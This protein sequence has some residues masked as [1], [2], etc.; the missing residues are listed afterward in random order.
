MEKW[1]DKGV[2][3]GGSDYF[4]PILPNLK[5]LTLDAALFC[6]MSLVMLASRNAFVYEGG[7]SWIS[8][9]S[10]AVTMTTCKVSE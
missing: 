9:S 7:M 5:I 8:C 4:A 2:G 10:P 3:K 6:V 1:V